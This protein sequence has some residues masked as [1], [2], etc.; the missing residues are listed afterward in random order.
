[1]ACS[2]EARLRLYSVLTD[3]E[4]IRSFDKANM[5]ARESLLDQQSGGLANPSGII[6]DSSA[7]ERGLPRVYALLSLRILLICGAT[8]GSS[9]INESSQ[10]ELHKLINDLGDSAEFDKAADGV[11]FAGGAD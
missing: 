5:R 1:M 10:E 4:T 3:K 6:L 11:T 8:N 7:V 2:I 9:N